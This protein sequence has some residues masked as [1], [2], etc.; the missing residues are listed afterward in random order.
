MCVERST[1]EGSLL[2]KSLAWLAIVPLACMMACGR[3]E[4][5]ANEVR[6]ALARSVSLAS[7]S[8]IFI[9]YLS[10]GRSTD[11]FAHGHLHYLRDEI[12]KTFQET[13]KLH[14]DQALMNAVNVDR[15]QLRLLAL[16]ID[17]AS[18]DLEQGGQALNASAKRIRE[19]RITLQHMSSFL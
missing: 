3:H 11:T 8:E 13:S 14:P 12:E 4:A 15:A 18:R 2:L 7:E 1:N 9:D 5:S 19:I 6:S 17:G 16:E 10:Q